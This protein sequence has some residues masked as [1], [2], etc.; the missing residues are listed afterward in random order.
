V[1]HERKAQYS[2]VEW[3]RAGVAVRN[4]AAPASQ[5]EAASRL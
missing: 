4:F 3:T 5:P 2:A 1:R